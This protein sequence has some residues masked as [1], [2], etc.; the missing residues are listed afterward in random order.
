VADAPKKAAPM[1]LSKAA[2]SVIP[3]SRLEGCADEEDS[4]NGYIP[5]GARLSVETHQVVV[6]FLFWIVP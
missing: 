1:V 5:Q 4:D 6:V 2:W 3:S